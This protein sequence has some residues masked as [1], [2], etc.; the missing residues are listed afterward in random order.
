MI[1]K[2]IERED[3]LWSRIEKIEQQLR[4][5]ELYE[6]DRIEAKIQADQEKTASELSQ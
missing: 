5:K 4:E 1:E 6:Y 3:K 2:A